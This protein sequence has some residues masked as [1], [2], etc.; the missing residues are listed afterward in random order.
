M[1]WSI[2]GAVATMRLAAALTI[3]QSRLVAAAL[4]IFVGGDC[5]DDEHGQ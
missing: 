5:A 1:G 4:P 3:D 2:V